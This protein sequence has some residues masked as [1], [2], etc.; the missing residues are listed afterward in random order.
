MGHEPEI[1]LLADR[2]LGKLARVLR[3][4]GHDVEYVREGDPLDIAERAAKSG[5]VLLTRDKRLA[6]RGGPAR[7]LFVDNDY[8]FHQARQVIRDLDLSIDTGF[9]RCVEDNGLLETA[10]RTSV[11]GNV[12]AYVLE[13]APLLFR[14]ARC[15][16]VYWEGTHVAAMRAMIASLKDEPLVPGADDPEEVEAGDGSGLG[17]LEPLVDLHQAFEVLFL[18]HRLALMDGD[19]V[20]ALKMI[21][22]FNLC[23]RRHIED[24]RDLILPLYQKSGQVKGFERGADPSLFENEHAK[25]L[26]HLERMEASAEALGREAAGGEKLRTR[27]LQLLD[28]EKVFTDLLEHHDLRERTHLYPALEAVLAEEERRDLVERMVGRSMAG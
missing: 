4:I 7:I 16:R 3:M 12:P 26:D 1:A 2:M 24:E 8:P 23:M 14:C 13:T 5:R 27:C 21:R 28:R 17:T 18:K 19:L 20:R 22:R 15:G 25:I 6:A 9:R 10:D 11:Q